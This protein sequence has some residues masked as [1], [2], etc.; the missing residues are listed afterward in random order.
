MCYQCISISLGCC[1]ELEIT[2]V[3]TVPI[4]NHVCW[5][6]DK[7]GV[8]KMVC[9]AKFSPWFQWEYFCLAQQTVWMLHHPRQF[10]T[11]VL[12]IILWMNLFWKVEVAL[13]RFCLGEYFPFLKLLSISASQGLCMVL[14]TDILL[15]IGMHL[16]WDSWE[17]FI[18]LIG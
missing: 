15:S 17:K 11:H 8:K 7:A 3:Y 6:K 2:P 4:Y 5:T 10:T 9:S 1:S 18:K 16:N 12:I 14:T 13:S